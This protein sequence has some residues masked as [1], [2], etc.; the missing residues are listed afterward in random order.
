MSRAASQTLQKAGFGAVA[1]TFCHC[2]FAP[3]GRH[4]S[5][6]VKHSV[7][8]DSTLSA[9]TTLRELRRHCANLNP[10]GVENSQTMILGSGFPLFVFTPKH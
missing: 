10:H 7:S 6:Q 2:L 3:H 4:V 1:N 5:F 9:L 8:S